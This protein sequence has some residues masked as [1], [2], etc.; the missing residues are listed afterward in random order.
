VS[1]DAASAA[2]VVR[3]LTGLNMSRIAADVLIT[4][5]NASDVATLSQPLPSALAAGRAQAT[6]L[7]YAPFAPPY[8]ASGAPNPRFETT[9]AGWLTYVKAVCQFVKSVYGSDHF[10]VEVW[11]ELTNGS[12]YL[13]ESDYFNPVPDPGSVGNVT[14]AV[15]ARTIQM[16]RDP[17]NGLTDVQVGDGFANQTPFVSGATVPTGT[18][19]IDKHPYHGA[20]FF[21][22]S[23]EDGSPVNALGASAMIK[24]A[25]TSVEAF[26]PTFTSFFPEYFLSGLQTET[27]MRDLSPM[28]TTVGGTPHG[29]STAPVGGEPPVMWITEYNLSA[30]QGYVLGMPPAD[31][32]ELQAKAALRF[33]VAYASE[34]VPAIDLYAAKSNPSYQGYP[35]YQLIS[36]NFFT[37]VDANPSSDPSSL[38]GA[39][40]QAVG[41]LTTTL[42]GA[43]SIASP[44]Q[45]ALNAI[46]TDSQNSQ[47]TGN[48]TTAYPNLYDSDVLAF[49]PFQLSSNSF[50]AAVY[51]M[52]DDLARAYTST[53]AAGYTPYDLPPETYQLTIGN[54]DGTTA[55]VS[56][57]DPLTGTAQPATIV[58]R[59][60]TQIVVQLPVTDSPRMLA[61]NNA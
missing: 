30:Y 18:N 61:I 2:K 17:A 50:V 32:P 60:S 21:P 57:T 20:D 34:G 59:T 14:S 58:S 40:M 6:T 37:A 53:P 3:G 51:V 47:F 46:S 27:L 16:L 19:A 39:V 43:Q 8:L 33:Y 22:G 10:D 26:R 36:P 48:G 35:V 52:T 24:V 44:R 56:L 38:G 42:S 55:T 9:L 5:V 1:L 23:T 49:F 45:L 25:G 12:Q 4:S 7:R 54:L 29:A 28:T 31:L 13:Y 15:L 41:R 11:N